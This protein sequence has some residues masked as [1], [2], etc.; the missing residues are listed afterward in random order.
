MG[1]VRCAGRERS[2]VGQSNA[3]AA[4][5]AL[6]AH[7]VGVVVTTLAGEAGGAAGVAA[8][9]VGL[10]LVLDAVEATHGR[11][12]GAVA[13]EVRGWND[14]GRSG[15]RFTWL[16]PAHGHVVA[17]DAFLV[18]D[19]DVVLLAGG[20][21]DLARYLVR[22]FGGVVPVSAAGVGEHLGDLDL[23]GRGGI[24][25][26]PELAGVVRRDPEHVVPGRCG[27]DVAADPLTVVVHR[28]DGTFDARPESGLVR[29]SAR[30]NVGHGRPG[31][32]GPPLPR[33]DSDATAAAHTSVAV[34]A[35]AAVVA[36]AAVRADPAAID[37]SFILVLDAVA[38]TCAG[39]ARPAAIDAGLALVLD[40][41]R[42][43]DASSCRAG[44]VDAVVVENADLAVLAGGTTDSAAVD[45]GLVLVLEAVNAA[46]GAGRAR[47][48]AIDA[49]FTLV[50]L[51]VRAGRVAGGPVAV[52]T[53]AVAVVV[54]LLVFVASGSADGA[55]A[56]DIGLALILDAVVARWGGADHDV[57]PVTDAVR[58]RVARLAVDAGRP[59]GGTAAVH[60]TLVLVHGSVGAGGLAD[61]SAADVA[62][63]IA[64]AATVL[65]GDAGGAADAAAVD[66]GLVL[67]LDA[68]AAVRGTPAEPTVADVALA[69]A[70][71]VARQAGAAACG[72]GASAA[73]GVGLVLVDDSVEAGIGRRG[74][75]LEQGH[76]VSPAVEVGCGAPAGT[77]VEVRRATVLPGDRRWLA[78]WAV[79]V[80]IRV[81]EGGIRTE[82]ARCPVHEDV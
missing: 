62:D 28:I 6:V 24:G 5:A 4:T 34:T 17:P 56:V 80:E 48:T 30:R 42:A 16:G 52:A 21:G 9:D 40:A 65:S 67:V 61:A 63:T 22:S 14:L 77:A 1:D 76:G 79:V 13:V 53:D 51:A 47:P 66:V 55:A 70:V 49:L 8:V 60:V 7:A 27:R 44:V 25:A 64:V 58:I 32:C 18:E 29:G 33:D 26:Q 3:S 71:D 68:V 36:L 38:A 54:A 19:F 57:A 15:A 39:R 35:R 45:I 78:R 10:V 82:R 41:I 73:V 50:L 81:G 46:A 43:A 72:T 2:I 75:R 74:T 12:T 31:D 69:V 11:L 23:V 37:I 59:A 20:E